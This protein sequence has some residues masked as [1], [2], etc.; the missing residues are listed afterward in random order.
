[1][2]RVV[3]LKASELLEVIKGDMST[4]SE[5][6]SRIKG[7]HETPSKGSVSP[8][9]MLAEYDYAVFRE[10]M[11]ETCPDPDVVIRSDNVEE[12][13]DALNRYFDEYAPE[14]T[15]LRCYV[16]NISLY[17]VFIAKRPLHPPGFD[18]PDLKVISG[19]DGDYY[20]SRK[21]RISDGE[22]TLCRYCV[23]RPI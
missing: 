1:M 15:D 3:L 23:C 13:R 12:F 19:P 18:S 7:V 20:C 16:T 11:D 8:I 6:I 22:P 2:Y 9:S 5:Y 10:I 21:G 4:I 17:L 14:E